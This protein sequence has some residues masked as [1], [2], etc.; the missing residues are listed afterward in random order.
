MFGGVLFLVWAFASSLSL[1]G[2]DNG[3]FIIFMAISI[4][5]FVVRYFFFH[6]LGEEVSCL[7]KGGDKMSY[8]CIPYFL[9]IQRNF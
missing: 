7:K 9:I 5:I 8:V 2:K 4:F 1:S 3:M 6:L